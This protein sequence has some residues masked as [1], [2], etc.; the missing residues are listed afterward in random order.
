MADASSLLI[1]K[2]KW[3]VFGRSSRYVAGTRVCLCEWA[4][5]MLRCVQVDVEAA[6]TV[7]IK[8]HCVVAGR[9]K[10]LRI[11]MSGE[12]MNLPLVEYLAGISLNT[13]NATPTQMIARYA[14][15][16]SFFEGIIDVCSGDEVEVFYKE[17]QERRFRRANPTELDTIQDAKIFSTESS[18]FFEQ[19]KTAVATITDKTL[20]DEVIELTR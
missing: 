12:G 9:Y 10:G 7:L 1:A 16:I 18:D 3:L 4:R 19:K 15:H 20:A 6:P 14:H 17:L 2:E 5:E 13:V 11:A 8:R